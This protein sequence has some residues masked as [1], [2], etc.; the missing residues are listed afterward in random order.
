MNGTHRQ[1]K[2]V[3]TT[4]T[5]SHITTLAIKTEN[6][7]CHVSTIW[8]VLLTWDC[9]WLVLNHSQ[10]QSLGKACRGHH[11]SEFRWKMFAM[12]CIWVLVL[13]PGLVYVSACILAQLHYSFLTK[14]AMLWNSMKQT[15]WKHSYSFDVH[16][17]TLR[18]DI[19]GYLFGIFMSYKGPRF[20]QAISSSVDR[21]K[22]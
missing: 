9:Q 22:L 7:L 13:T 15:S 18:W 16:V 17:K 4:M 5:T 11:S 20:L 19:F 12:G 8:T 3:P 14:D 6:F 2:I 21:L 1:T 10:R